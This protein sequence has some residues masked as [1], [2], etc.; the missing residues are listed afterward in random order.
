VVDTASGA[1]T[2]IGKPAILNGVRMSPDGNYFIVTT[3]HRPFSYSYPARMFPQEVEVWDRSGKVLKKIS[4]R[5]LGAQ[6]GRGGGG[7]A[8]DDDPAATAPAAGPR[9]QEWKPNE[10]A[11]LMWFEGTG[12]GGGGR[13]GRG[14]AA[15]APATPAAPAHDRVLTLKA[16]FNGTPAVI[17]EIDKR[18]NGLLFTE[19]PSLAIIDSGGGGG[20]GGGGGG[21]ARGG[22]R[23]PQPALLI[24]FDHPKDPP[25]PLWTRTTGTSYGNP[26]APLDKTLPGGG[27][28]VVLDG[29]NVFLRG[30]GAS[31]TGDHPFLTKY[32]MATGQSTPLFKS[33][34][35][36]YEVFEA[37]LDA[38]GDKFL[39]RRESP[40]EPPNYFVRTPAGQLT[41]VTHYP[42]PQPIMRKVSKQLVNYRRSDGVEMSFVLYLPPDYKQGTP[43]PTV[44]WAYP[45]EFEDA[46][47]AGEVTGSTLHFTEVTGYSEIF[48]ALHGYAVLDNASMP[49]VGDRRTVNDK[50]V[51]QVVDDA[52][53][54]IDKAVSMGVTDRNRVGVGGHSYGA[55]MTDNLLA[56]CD[57][58]KAGIAE[59]G[60]PNRTLTP[61]GFQNERR[62]IWQA[63]ETYL[64][65]SPFMYAD[66]L[67]TPLL[68]IHG[69][70][71]DNDGTFPIQSERM[72]EAVRGNGGTVRLVFLPYEAHGY[73]GKETIEHV[74]WEKFE[75]FDK[76]VKNAK[77]L[78]ASK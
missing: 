3:I 44:V 75:W 68:L 25:K 41:A 12:G 14:A 35:S 63:P 22:A 52:K 23:N 47:A 51:E 67:K 45:R 37:L 50:F 30:N 40:T 39:T 33:D 13:G 20:R 46:D 59:S 53:A 42:D 54:A 62:T 49:I 38:H 73:R 19:N 34:D 43:L 74:L 2:P 27:R 57:L 11:T 15:A 56:H 31:P 5:P 26:G 7:A 66:K 60:A 72:F 61:F 16:P 29:D 58:F 21:G 70:M 55:F 36:H 78:A 48:F 1:L 65:M 18:I 69:E 4:S 6:G 24:N 9:N 77:P 32:N 8:P 76:Y 28:L 17:F 10:P 64:K 71:D